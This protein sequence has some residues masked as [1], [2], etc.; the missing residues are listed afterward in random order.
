M[1]YLIIGAGFLVV[2]VDL[3]AADAAFGARLLPATIA[4]VV[5]FRQ[6]VVLDMID[7]IVSLLTPGPAAEEGRPPGI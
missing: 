4:L 6:N 2:Q 5:G 1:V 7:R 3:S